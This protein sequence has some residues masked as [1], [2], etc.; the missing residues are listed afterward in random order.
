MHKLSPLSFGHLRGIAESLFEIHHCNEIDIRFPDM[1]WYFSGIPIMEMIKFSLSETNSVLPGVHFWA[2]NYDPDYPVI[3]A[4][5]YPVGKLRIQDNRLKADLFD[6]NIWYTSEDWIV[7]SSQ[8]DITNSLLSGGSPLYFTSDKKQYVV[9]QDMFLFS[10]SLLIQVRP[11]LI[12]NR[13]SSCMRND[14]KL[15]PFSR[16]G[17][18]DAITYAI[19]LHEHWK[20][21]STSGAVGILLSL[22]D[23]SYDSHGRLINWYRYGM[24]DAKLNKYHAPVFVDQ[25]VMSEFHLDIYKG[26]DFFDQQDEVPEVEK[27]IEDMQDL[28]DTH[29]ADIKRYALS[30]DYDP[31]AQFKVYFTQK[32]VILQQHSKKYKTET[33]E[34]PLNWYDI[35]DGAIGNAYQYFKMLY[36][37]TLT[38]APIVC[39]KFK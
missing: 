23:L 1:E 31:K 32:N 34:I 16:Q 37:C 22:R 19:Q 27:Y 33:D 20:R 28:I 14:I 4:K 24:N 15:F 10:E 18:C 12:G 11:D 9:R 5:R 30:L 36:A 13:P 39:I 8:I 38:Y 21:K 6:K 7:Q 17:I 26:N 29:I 2:E 3:Q 25:I 35:P